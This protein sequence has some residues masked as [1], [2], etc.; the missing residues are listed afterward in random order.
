MARLIAL[1]GMPGS[2][3]STI[4]DL[5]KNKYHFG[6]VYF[7]GIVVEKLKEENLPVNE[8]NERKIREALRKKHGMAAFATLNIPKIEESLKNGDTII[9]GLYSWEEY[10]VLKDKF[11]EMIVWAIYT[12]FILRAKRLSRRA[13]RPLTAEQLKS[14]DYAQIENSHQAGPI[15]LADW[16]FINDGSKTKLVSEVEEKLNA[17]KS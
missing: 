16:T 4:T 5:L 6:L 7:G 14:R 12:P 11:P 1:V 3:K 17:Q 15:A 2:G 9:D 10:L 13:V 8:V